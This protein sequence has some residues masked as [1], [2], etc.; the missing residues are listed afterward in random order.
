MILF[1]WQ[2]RRETFY[3]SKSNIQG[4]GVFADKDYNENS[5]LFTGIEPNRKITYLGSKINHCNKVNT[6]LVNE[7]N[8][9]NIYSKRKINKGE[10]LL[11]DYNNTPEFIKKPDKNWKC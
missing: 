9:W 10:E 3:I 1:F 7:E 4:V 6:Y 11:I 2:N 8:G 5:F